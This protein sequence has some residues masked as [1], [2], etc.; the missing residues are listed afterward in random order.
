M[1]PVFTLFI[2]YPSAHR[3]KA[4]RGDYDVKRGTG[5]HA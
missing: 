2:S 4:H 3:Q 1:K 5:E